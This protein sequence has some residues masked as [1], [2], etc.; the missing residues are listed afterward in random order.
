VGILI[1]RGKR[2]EGAQLPGNA[3]ASHH[4]IHKRLNHQGHRQAK[5]SWEAVNG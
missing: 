1:L 2:V 5:K 4:F 3:S